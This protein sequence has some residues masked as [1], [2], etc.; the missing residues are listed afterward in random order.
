MFLIYILDIYSQ[1]FVIYA[2]FPS[3]Q[4][5]FRKTKVWTKVH[6]CPPIKGRFIYWT[7]QLILMTFGMGC[8]TE[9]WT[10]FHPWPCQIK[11]HIHQNWLILTKKRACTMYMESITLTSFIYTKCLIKKTSITFC[12][13]L[14]TTNL[15]TIND[16]C[17]NWIT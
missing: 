2:E 5:K 14:S 7:N 13:R 10:C 15:F 17:L 1:T 16:H 4:A 6:V 8:Q 3:W 12:Y 9:G 11:L